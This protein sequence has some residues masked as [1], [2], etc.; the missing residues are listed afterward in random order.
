MTRQK[1]VIT[2]AGGGMGRA[3]ARLFA[4]AHDLVLTDLKSQQFDM[5]V[6]ELREDGYSVEAHAGDLSS[7]IILAALAD[8]CDGRPFTLIHTAGIGPSQ[9]DWRTIMRI[10]L[11]A[12][13]AL[14]RAV[15]SRLVP[16]ST[17]VLIASMASHM[18]PLSPE[19]ASLLA[20]PL[21]TGFLDKLAPFIAEIGAQMGPTGDQDLAYVFSK[22]AV[23]SIAE[24]RAEAWGAK[25][26]RINS[27]SPGVIMTPMGRR[28][29]AIS[30][31]AAAHG[32]AAAL[33]RR[34][35]SMDIALAA[36]F[37]VSDAAAYVTGTDLRVDGGSIAVQRMRSGQ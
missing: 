28:E 11:V 20:D 10:N 18:M 32:D 15:E 27:I 36:H 22:T 8:S 14:L 7:D 24:L 19:I 25:G 13:E 37:L 2:G 33:R 3:C 1:V 6:E 12:V 34:G 29:S 21:Q 31:V 35:T 16:G 17:A 30:P 23:R 5:F 9:G 4:N 26:A